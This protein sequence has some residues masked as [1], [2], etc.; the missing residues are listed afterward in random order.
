MSVSKEELIDALIR[1]DG[2][3]SEVAKT[4][5][6][7]ARTVRRRIQEDEELKAVQKECQDKLVDLAESELRK[8]VQ[9]GSIKAILFTLQ[10][11]GRDRGFGR[12]LRIDAS[13]EQ[14]A[15][16]VLYFPDDGREEQ[17]HVAG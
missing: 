11:W 5:K 9:A 3:A 17:K 15:N 4:V 12:E 8:A 1:C 6:V 13:V 16:V 14:R 7:T 2:I 10:T